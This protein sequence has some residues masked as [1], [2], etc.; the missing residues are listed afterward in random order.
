MK[1]PMS[2]SKR[3]MLKV[4]APLALSTQKEAIRAVS[5]L[6]ERQYPGGEKAHFRVFPPLLLIPPRS[7]GF[8]N[9]LEFFNDKIGLVNPREN[10]TGRLCRTR[11]E[12]ELAER[13]F[14]D[15]LTPEERIELTWQLSREQWE[16]KNSDVSRLSRH[17]AGVV[18]R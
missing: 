12:V 15:K 10:V 17:R 1:S 11:E 14:L 16:W 3:R 9:N 8:T 2:D 13:E 5:R 6:I 18:R 4:N 7:L